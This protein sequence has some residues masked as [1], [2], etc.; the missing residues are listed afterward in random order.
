MHTLSL[1]SFL[2]LFLL[3]HV[4]YIKH[5]FCILNGNQTT[6][7][8]V[9]KSQTLCLG[10][11]LHKPQIA[12]TV[13]S[14]S[15]PAKKKSRD[16]TSQVKWLFL[17]YSLQQYHYIP[18]TVPILA[19]TFSIQLNFQTPFKDRFTSGFISTS[20]ISGP[21]GWK[22]NQYLFSSLFKPPSHSLVTDYLIHFACSKNQS[23]QQPCRISAV[24]ICLEKSLQF[25]KI[26][27]K[28]NLGQS[29]SNE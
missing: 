6:D 22:L 24:I 9:Y 16:L 21:L 17:M 7:L 18:N 14:Q 19:D 8:N 25:A 20:P 15:F 27:F 5:I 29:Q 26:A 28:E 3:L 2:L 11:S 4:Q 12:L 13:S 1:L 10:K 23:I